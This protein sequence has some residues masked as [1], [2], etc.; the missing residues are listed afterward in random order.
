[1]QRQG[2]HVPRAAQPLDVGG[3]VRVVVRGGARRDGV[4][5]VGGGGVGDLGQVGHR[6]VAGL[7]LRLVA[8]LL[9]VELVPAVDGARHADA[10]T[11]DSDDGV[12][13]EHVG[14]GPGQP[15]RQ[16]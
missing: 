6:I 8:H 1:D 5:A 16:L 12:G 14:A 4:G 3:G 2:G 7:E 11:V 9:T 15:D 10:A 13:G